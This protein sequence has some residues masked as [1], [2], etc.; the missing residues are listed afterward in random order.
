MGK[1]LYTRYNLLLADIS[2]KEEKNKM[3]R[4]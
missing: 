4:K 2:K 1:I 3:R